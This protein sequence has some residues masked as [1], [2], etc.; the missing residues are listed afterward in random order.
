MAAPA[1]IY[2]VDESLGVVEIRDAAGELLTVLE[3]TADVIQ[4]V[5]PDLVGPQGATGAAGVAGPLGPQGPVGP[6]GPFAPTF[7]QHFASASLL[8]FI[9]HNLDTYPTVDIY[10]LD[11]FAISGD[12]FMP[13]RNSVVVTFDV[14]VAGTAVL[15]A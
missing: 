15:K 10:D 6:Q 2:T 1:E 12:V 13:D 4:I 14:A 11:G 3:P 8:W 9:Q 7:V 5:S